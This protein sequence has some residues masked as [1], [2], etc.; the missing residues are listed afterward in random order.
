MLVV[1]EHGLAEDLGEL[2]LYCSQRLEGHVT[3]GMHEECAEALEDARTLAE[4]G[5][6][7]PNR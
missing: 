1:D 7:D 2:C 5:S 3:N 6:E 4:T